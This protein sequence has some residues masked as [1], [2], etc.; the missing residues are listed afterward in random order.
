MP[1]TTGTPTAERAKVVWYH[2]LI[3]SQEIISIINLTIRSSGHYLPVALSI[4]I[5]DNM[6]NT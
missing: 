1:A 3:V 5:S 2:Y 4:I 6:S